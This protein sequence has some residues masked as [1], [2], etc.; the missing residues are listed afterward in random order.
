MTGIANQYAL[1]VFSLASKE[2]RDEEFLTVLETFV[3]GMNEN[4]YKFFAHP[5]IS[6][7]EKKQTL[8][9]VVYDKLL[10]NFLK[11]L[12]DNDR[13]A[14]VEAISLEYKNILD[15]LNKIMNVVVVSNKPLKKNNLDKIKNKLKEKYNR[16]IQIE[17]TIDKD[18]IGG[19]RIEFE[20]NVI[21]E[22]INKQLN[23]IKSSL[24]E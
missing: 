18:I 2:K 7:L 11:V 1:A 14:L 3:K 10:L 20:G 5:K 19:F 22:T 15:N 16:K 17:E 8:E 4:T 23:D 13:F 21:D 24:T 12:I 6:I 9:K